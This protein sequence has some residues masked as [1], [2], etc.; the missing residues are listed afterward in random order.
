[1]EPKMNETILK[2]G[3][4][5]GQKTKFIQKWGLKSASYENV[6]KMVESDQKWVTKYRASLKKGGTNPPRI[7]TLVH[8]G[9][10]YTYTGP[11][12]E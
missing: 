1:M 2:V 5:K 3:E 10:R 4:I 7:P 8:I 9:S 6:G 12:R 11:N